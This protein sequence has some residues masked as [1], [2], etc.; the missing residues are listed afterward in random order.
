[1]RESLSHN[2]LSRFGV[3]SAEPEGYSEPEG[4]TEADQ[5]TYLYEIY[6]VKEGDTLWHIAQEKLGNPLL[7]RE[8]FQVNPEIA[9]S[10]VV[11]PGQVIRIPVKQSELDGRPESE[12]IVDEE[13]QADD[14]CTEKTGPGKDQQTEAKTKT[15]S[16]LDTGGQKQ[17]RPE[18]KQQNDESVQGKTQIN[19]GLDAAVAGIMGWSVASLRRIRNQSIL[20]REEF[21]KLHRKKDNRPFLRWLDGKLQEAGESGNDRGDEGNLPFAGFPGLNFNDRRN[22]D[23]DIQE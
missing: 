15:G 7:W 20:D 23:A 3:Y 10:D 9:D 18:N 6:T 8:I 4:Y 5:P 11:Y 1:M 21:K 13:A 22:Y 14:E 17:N 12:A 16:K 19:S 2:D